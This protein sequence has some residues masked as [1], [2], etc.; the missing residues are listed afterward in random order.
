MF[1]FRKFVLRRRVAVHL[2]DGS[3][4]MGVLYQKAGP[5]LVLK[6][7]TLHEESAPEA[8]PLDGETIIERSR[9]VFIQ[10]L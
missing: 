10:A 5:L 3:V 4:V 2:D 1:P 9:V 6:D 7:A 8:L